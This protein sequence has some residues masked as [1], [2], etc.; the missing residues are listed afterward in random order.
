MTYL[1]FNALLVLLAIPVVVFVV[2]CLLGLIR[3]ADVSSVDNNDITSAIL[4]PAHNEAS[5]IAKTLE[6]LKTQITDND[7]VV[8]IA[9][10]CEDSTADIARRFGFTVIERQSDRERGKGYALDFG[11]H[12]LKQRD[13]SPD[14]VIIVDADCIVE[15]NALS[16]LKQAVIARQRPVQACYLML[17]GDVSRIAVKISEFAFLVKNKIRLR[18]LSRLGMPVPLTGTGMAFPWEAIA[19]AQLATGDIVEDMRL[20]VELAEHGVGATYC[21]QACVYSYFPTSEAAEATQRERWEHGHL[22]T[23]SQ[24]APRLFKRAIGKPSIEALGMMLDLIIPPLSLLVMIMGAA[25]GFFLIWGL[26]FSQWALFYGASGLFALLLVS[27]SLTWLSH[28]RHILSIKELLHIPV[29]IISKIVIYLGYI[30]RKQT[31]WIRTDRD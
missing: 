6:N 10:N 3:P 20:G 13:S 14:V 24:F 1:L 7:H 25:W 8:V 5:G 27:I 19:Q 18:G 15:D 23:L 17:R 9:D 16:L 21:D 12:Y 4:I 29:Y 26:L 2:E 28:G 30:V 11:M 31:K 22:S